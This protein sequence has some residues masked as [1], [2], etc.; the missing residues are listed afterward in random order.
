MRKV[1]A[2]PTVDRAV[3]VLITGASGQLGSDLKQLLD[4]RYDVVALPREELDIA[5][6]GAL[7]TTFE[8]VAPTLVLNCAAFH[9]VE[10]CETDEDRSFEVNARAVKR[11]AQRCAAT[12]ARLVH[13]STNYVFDG[14]SGAPYI[15]DDRPN[16]RSVYAISKL[17]GEQMA[18]AYCPDALVVRSAGL[19]GLHGSVSKGGNFVTRMLGR[20]RSD[21]E[22]R[23]VADQL[24]TPTYTG[25]LAQAL[26]D[27]VGAGVTGV[28]HLTNGGR[29]SWHE[30]TA[31]IMENAGIQ[32][33]IEAVSTTRPAGTAERPL[34][35]VLSSAR[36][37]GAALA[38]MRHWR[39]ALD[40]YMS[41]AGLT[42]SAATR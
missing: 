40:D 26:M 41:L 32:V 42:A 17:A 2:L 18:L 31:A 1:R 29:C 35:G 36:V 24:L 4:D 28:L 20:A 14:R 19:Y 5:D 11:M 37:Q 39:E 21:G 9:N 22:L 12:D 38:P 15:E 7:E 23:M 3:R 6:D 13:L 8:R 10:V 25:D 33:R 30:F 16:P 27:A 34:N